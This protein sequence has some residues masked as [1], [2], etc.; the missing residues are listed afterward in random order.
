MK[1]DTSSARLDPEEA[2]S[3]IESD[4]QGD[5]SK[6]YREPGNVLRFLLIRPFSLLSVLCFASLLY[7]RHIIVIVCFLYTT[8]ISP[9]FSPCFFFSPTLYTLYLLVPCTIMHFPSLTTVLLFV[10]AV[11]VPLGPHHA[12]ETMS[13]VRTIRSSVIASIPVLWRWTADDKVP[14]WSSTE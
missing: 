1:S 14:P 8:P 3:M 6:V 4:R 7:S 12:R 11:A 5:Y 2:C 13:Q 9:S 10:G